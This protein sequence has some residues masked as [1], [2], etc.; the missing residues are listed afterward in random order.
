[1]MTN[2]ERN[3][4]DAA[5]QFCMTFYGNGS[6]GAVVRSQRMFRMLQA[7]EDHRGTV[8]PEPLKHP[9]KDYRAPE[10]RGVVDGERIQGF[11][12]KQSTK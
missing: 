2:S 7:Y 3:F 6:G 12:Q 1:M 8:E 5:R 9:L 11:A 10:D 4:F